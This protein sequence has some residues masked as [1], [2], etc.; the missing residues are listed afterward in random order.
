MVQL[1]ITER[2]VCRLGKFWRAERTP[3][4]SSHRMVVQLPPRTN[5]VAERPYRHPA[6]AFRKV[7][8]LNDLDEI[9]LEPHLVGLALHE[10]TQDEQLARRIERDPRNQLVAV[11]H[12]TSRAHLMIHFRYS[13]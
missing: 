11:V 6:Q 13:S 12:R 2:H 3:K 1:D 8:G 7:P 4:D 9:R 5:H 10:L